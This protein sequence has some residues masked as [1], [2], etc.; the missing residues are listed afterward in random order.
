MIRARRPSGSGWHLRMPGPSVRAGF[1]DAPLIGLANSPI[2]AT[3]EPT[4]MAALWPML[5]D[6]R[7]VKVKVTAGLMCNPDSWPQA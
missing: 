7:H 3:V 2:S 1:M 5:R 6:P 4:V